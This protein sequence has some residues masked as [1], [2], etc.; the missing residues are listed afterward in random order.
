MLSNLVMKDFDKRLAA[1]AGHNSLVYT[2]Y[3][4]DLILSTAD[5]SFTRQRAMLIVKSVFDE[6]R[7]EGLRPRTTKTVIA[8]PGAR[9]VVVGLLV[10]GERPRLT[11]AFRAKLDQHIYCLSKNGPSIH[12]QAR[13]FRSIFAMKR[14]IAGLLSY[15]RQVDPAFAV[16]LAEKF[17]ALHWPF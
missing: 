1:L 5:L 3:A 9:K 17:N 12:A 6:L 11:R 13:N 10:D 2:R 14:H 8:P 7:A 15:A 4:D 16:P